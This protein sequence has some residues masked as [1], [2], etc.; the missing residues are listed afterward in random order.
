MVS[1]MAES[2]GEGPG[3]FKRGGSSERSAGDPAA[4]VNG[5]T[6]LGLGIARGFG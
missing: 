5:V 1:V 3:W 2:M 4:A 6:E